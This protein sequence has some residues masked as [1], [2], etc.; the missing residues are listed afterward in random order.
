MN[1][2][3]RR[4][5]DRAGKKM[6]KRSNKRINSVEY[7]QIMTTINVSK[8]TALMVLRDKGWGKKRILEFSEDF[9]LLLKT[10][11]EGYLSS[12]DIAETITK[13]TGI[14]Y[15]QLKVE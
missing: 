3:E 7:S 1:R 6:Q 8:L 4:K 9:D 10:T 2:Q 11:S 14:P 13:E 12:V 5:R 15:E